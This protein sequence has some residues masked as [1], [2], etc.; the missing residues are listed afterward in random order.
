[1]T[2]KTLLTE[3]T[4]SFKSKILLLFFQQPSTNKTKIRPNIENGAI[5]TYTKLGEVP[6]VSLKALMRAH[7]L[8][9]VSVPH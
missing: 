7:L 8:I 5:Y 3:I 1:M 6:Q 9:V 2:L 4:R